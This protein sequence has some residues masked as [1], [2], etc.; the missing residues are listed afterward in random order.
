MARGLEYAQSPG[1]GQCL[2]VSNSLGSRV[3]APVPDPISIRGLNGL[4]VIVALHD[5]ESGLI[6]VQPGCFG[7]KSGDADSRPCARGAGYAPARLR[8]GSLLLHKPKLRHR[9]LWQT[10]HE[11]RYLLSLDVIQRGTG[12]RHYFDQTQHGPHGAFGPLHIEK[13]AAFAERLREV[14]ASYK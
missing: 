9:G 12:W 14:V 13:R 7:G 3:A 5:I 11:N 8:A 6:A 2:R 10:V 1:A 4:Y